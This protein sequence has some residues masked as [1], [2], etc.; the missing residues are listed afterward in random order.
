MTIEYSS[1]P[2]SE[3]NELRRAVWAAKLALGRANK[4]RNAAMRGTML[5]AISKEKARLRRVAAQLSGKRPPSD[6]VEPD[7]ET[8]V[9]GIPCGVVIESITPGHNGGW[10]E[11]P[12]DTE[13]EWSLVD[14]GGYAALWLEEKMTRDDE[15]NI[16]SECIEHLKSEA[17]K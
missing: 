6:P 7:F 1:D 9:D 8:I 16:Y 17:E 15:I 14:R 13:I 4:S 11:P 12:A 5:T 10:E 2:N 3:L